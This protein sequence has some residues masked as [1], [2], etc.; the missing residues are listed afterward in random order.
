MENLLA[1]QNYQ[2]LSPRSIQLPDVIEEEDLMNSISPLSVRLEL[3]RV[4][5][6]SLDKL[7]NAFLEQRVAENWE[8]GGVNNIRSWIKE[9]DMEGFIKSSLG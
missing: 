2:D 4:L 5:L 9:K 3:T 7:F 6:T 1:F 8:N